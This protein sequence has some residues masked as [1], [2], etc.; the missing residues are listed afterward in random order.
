M[1]TSVRSFLSQDFSAHSDPPLD[2]F[3]TCFLD[4][5]SPGILNYL[6]YIG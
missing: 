6:G 4:V 2:L 5:A 1:T 3:Y